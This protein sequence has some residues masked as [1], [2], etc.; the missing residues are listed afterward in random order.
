M[1]LLA[2]TC[3]D[4]YI[5]S[6]TLL[7]TEIINIVGTEPSSHHEHSQICLRQIF[8]IVTGLDALYL[9][10][11]RIDDVK[12]TLITT[13]DDVSHNRTTRF[14]YI[15]GAANHDDTPW[16]KQLFIN[17]RCKSNEIP[18]KDNI[19]IHNFQMKFKF[20]LYLCIVKPFLSNH[21]KE[22]LDFFNR[23]D[24]TYVA[25]RTIIYR[26]LEKSC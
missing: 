23:V 10:F 19:I 20:I 6:D 16:I 9:I 25:I 8:Y 3:R 22:D 7:T 14:M 26:T 4:D 21:A 17:H 1:C 15:V 18:C 2:E 13:V 24:V 11:L 12:F 5:G